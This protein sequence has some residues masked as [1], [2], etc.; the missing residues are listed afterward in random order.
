[1]TTITKTPHF[2]ALVFHPNA[3]DLISPDQFTKEQQTA[4]DAFEIKEFYADGKGSG[5]YY[6]NPGD[7]D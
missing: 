1:M 6:T 4:I 3:K 7:G 2:G 5:Y